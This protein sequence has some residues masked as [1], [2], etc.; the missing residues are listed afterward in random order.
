LRRAAVGLDLIT[1]LVFFLFV[2]KKLTSRKSCGVERLG[3]D[4][5]P[6]LIKH[7]T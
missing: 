7:S 2:L 5:M 3:L 1:Q 4:L 6:H